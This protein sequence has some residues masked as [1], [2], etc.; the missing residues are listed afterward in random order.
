MPVVL[1]L[2]PLA[3][4]GPRRPVRLKCKRL[5]VLLLAGGATFW[6]VASWCQVPALP[7]VSA[8]LP[9][10][11]D[12]SLAQF[13]RQV[14]QANKAVRTKRHE[15]ELAD[16]AVSRA[17]AVFQSQI[18]L[19][20]V[21]ASSRVQNTPEEALLRQGLGVYERKSQDYSAALS[22][23]LPSGAKVEVKGT[24]SRFLT[25]IN[26]GLRATDANDYKA[27]YGLTVT[28]PL[29]RD[30]GA[31]ST[32]SRIRVAELD[33]DAARQATADTESTTVA[34]AVLSYLD[35]GLA[36][37]R[38]AAWNEKIAMAE[39]LAVDAKSLAQ[40][41]RLPEIEIWEVENNLARYRAGASE[42]VQ[43]VIERVNKMRGLL[44]LTAAD[45]WAPLRAAD[46]LP[47]VTETRL[48]L[49][50]DLQ[51]AFEKRPD[52]RMR[53]LM[54]ERE[55]VQLVFAQNQKLPRIDL[56]ASYGQNGLAQSLQPSLEWSRTADFPSWSIGL[57]VA[58]TLGENRQGAADLRAALVR[59]EDAL[60]GLKAVESALAN[61]IDSSHAVIRSSIERHRLF[62]EI[63]DREGR[64]AQ[65]L[66]Q[67]L[68]AGRGD[69]R[70][71]LVSEERVINSRTAMQEQA[72]ANAKGL[73]LLA[74]AQGALLEQYP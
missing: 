19:A 68:L 24:M 14:L 42:A 74:L 29:A 30:G 46:A 62:A 71:L 6:S 35:L 61:D 37:Q 52:Y 60:L 72:V 3:Q 56:V 53:K 58:V 15:Q 33:A 13:V 27:F 10:P 66:R 49:A 23:L 4:P 34:D 31:E 54:V 50:Q 9:L 51:T 20:A 28:Q 38:L 69:M 12:L 39:R 43:A 18:E 21:N 63:A 5:V 65:A 64:L 16:T 36:Q 1:C 17:S 47:Q 70:E 48:D 22:T 45:G 32:R 25:N 11:V 67:K 44:L 40:Q 59:K 26:E 8:A 7:P 41:G 57:Q 73:A 2:R 55:G